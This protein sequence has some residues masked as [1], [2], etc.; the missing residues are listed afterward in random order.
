MEFALTGKEYTVYIQKKGNSVNVSGGSFCG[1][2]VLKS[3]LFSALI[4]N[5]L[6]SQTFTVTSESFC[7]VEVKEEVNSISFLFS[8]PNGI[9]NISFNVKAEYNDTFVFWT[10]D[11]I[12]KNNDFSVMEVGYPIPVLSAERFDLFV[13]GASGFVVKDAGVR[14]FD[15]FK[16]DYPCGRMTMQYFAAYCKSGGVYIGV[17]DP[18]AAVKRFTANSQNN[19]FNLVASLYGINSGNGANS[20][21]LPGGSKWQAFQGDWYDA[22]LI[23]ADFV[24][25]RTDWLPEIDN[26]GRVDVAKRFKEVPFWIC[27]YVPN[28]EYQGDNVPASAFGDYK[29]YPADHWYRGAIELKEQLG[30]PVAFQVY[31]WHKIPFN[32]E[33]PHFLP[34]KESFL[35][36]LKEL[37][38]NNILVVPYINAVSWD[39]R[40]DEAGHEINFNNTGF[41]GAVINEK[42]E[43][44]KIPYPQTSVKNNTPV[45]LAPMCPT[46][47]RWHD[48]IGDVV[49]KLETEV[50]VDGVYLDEIAAHSP[51]PCY[52]KE[53]THLPGGGSFWVENYNRMMKRLNSTKPKENYYYTECN[54]EPY[55]KSFDGFLSWIWVEEGQV[56]AFSA[57]Y[58]GYIQF[59]GRYTMGKQT[60][61]YD[62][63]KYATA[64]SLVY[65]QQI[66]WY[67]A[68]V[69]YKPK[70]LD[71]LKKIVR[72]RYKYTKLFNCSKMLRPP[73]TECDLAPIMSKGGNLYDG[74][75]VTMEQIVCGAWKYRNKE[76]LVIFLVNVSEYDTEYVV[77]FNADEYEICNYTLPDN[78]KIFGGECTVKGKIKGC[79]Y[80][81]F[82][83]D[84]KK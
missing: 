68:N 36:G 8:E 12:N 64:K 48:I 74:V 14:G 53:H 15:N 60:D 19:I 78:F 44:V 57:I 29:Q 66:G 18:E 20:F 41:R 2:S 22:A 11:V 70:W 76:K 32:V 59:I 52:N 26:E 72:L 46:Y 31:N 67:R 6:T 71:F 23:Y 42:G 43:V 73:V 1:I 56:P 33:Y 82:E 4:K 62:Y 84:L 75:P 77:K 45:D 7:R 50:K 69:I 49:S 28:S 38:K 55:I 54:A 47:E 5:N 40:D 35:V 24:H 37:Q 13:P 65:G 83:L 27:D 81:V 9:K 79:D 63:Y 30:V 58:G 16:R 51:Y 39:T 34:P 17:E 80:E 10:V 61:D 3:V 25:N 21:S